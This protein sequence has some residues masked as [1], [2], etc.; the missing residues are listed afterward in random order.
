MPR[1]KAMLSV[2]ARLRSFLTDFCHFGPKLKFIVIGSISLCRFFGKIREQWCLLRLKKESMPWYAMSIACT[3]CLR[4]RV[5]SPS[6]FL[7]FPHCRSN[8][9]NQWDRWEECQFRTTCI[10]HGIR[11]RLGIFTSNEDIPVR[12]NEPQVRRLFSA[13]PAI[14]CFLVASCVYKDK[15]FANT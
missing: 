3:C 6:L 12:S 15:C 8:N 9:R 1:R 14:G 4:M 11:Y 13:S 10:H 5:I 2:N 7:S